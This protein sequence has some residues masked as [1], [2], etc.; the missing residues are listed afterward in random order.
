MV[1]MSLGSWPVR[2]IAWLFVVLAFVSLPIDQL[3][4]SLS[5]D[6]YLIH[7]DDADTTIYQGKRQEVL[8]LGSDEAWLT[9]NLTYVRNHGASWG[10][11]KDLSDTV[12]PVLLVT[13]GLFFSMI[14][15]FAALSFQKNGESGVAFSL[16]L[17][18]AGSLGNLVDRLRLGYVVDFITLRGQLWGRAWGLPSFN[19][20]DMIIVVALFCL[21]TMLLRKNKSPQH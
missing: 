15:L 18:V 1:S 21:I 13:F 11:M 3:T 4:K 19:V 17:M 16:V 8:S 10:I 2:K 12:R 7:E 14:L 9:C 20:A 6:L 5:R